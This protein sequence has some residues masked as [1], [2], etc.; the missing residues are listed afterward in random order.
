MY[1][2]QILTAPLVG[3]LI[4]G[5]LPHG[6]RTENVLQANQRLAQGDDL[7]VQSGAKKLTYAGKPPLPDC[8]T[9]MQK[10]MA[11]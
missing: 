3:H 7:L 6:W 2:I 4:G 1:E 8:S 9:R 10:A 11:R 5:P